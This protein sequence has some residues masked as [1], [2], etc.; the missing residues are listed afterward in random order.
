MVSIPLTALAALASFFAQTAVATPSSVVSTRGAYIKRAA[1]CTFPSPP[2]TSSLSAAKTIT[3]TFDGGNV[4]YDRGEGACTGQKE[5]GDKDAVF[6]LESGAT[7]QNVVIGADQAEGIHCKGPCNIYNVWFEDVCEGA[8]TINQTSG[9]SNI[10][11]GGAKNA[12]DEV[13][14]HNGGGG[15]NINSYCVQ[16]FGTFYRSCGNCSTQYKRY[17]TIS[18]VIAK[19]GKLFASV[20]SNYGD[21]VTIDTRSVSY[22]NVTSPCDTFQANNSWEEPITLTTNTKNVNCV[23]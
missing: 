17:A 10:I 11:G 15:V 19:N 1:N 2:E 13:V 7:I 4:R 12:A 8:I 16:D 18:Y 5:G 6:I 9:T 21:V 20:N 14:Q 3:G 23:F 22:I